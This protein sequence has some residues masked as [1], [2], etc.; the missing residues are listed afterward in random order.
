MNNSE[1][2]LHKKVFTRAREHTPSP[3]SAKHDMT[4]AKL[5]SAE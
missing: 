4:I 1:E 5:K 2:K 3:S